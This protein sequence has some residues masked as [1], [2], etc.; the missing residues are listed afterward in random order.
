[1]P[2][3][4]QGEIVKIEIVNKDEKLLPYKELFRSIDGASEND[5]KVLA[6]LCC[7]AS[8]RVVDTDECKC[9]IEEVLGLENGEFDSAVAFWRGAK[10]LKI[11]K[12]T[13]KSETAKSEEKPQTKLENKLPDYT[14]SEMADKISQI[15]ELKGVIDECQ[16]IIGKIFS[17]SD[18]AVIVGMADRLALSGEFITMFVAY[19]VGMEKKS[20]RYVEK[21][22][23]ALYDEGID[24]VD[25][26]AKYIEN[27]EKCHEESAKIRRMMGCADRD[28]TPK[29]SNLL[30]KW[31]EEY[32]YGFEIIKKA[33][34][35]S[36]DRGI[37]GSF[38]PYMGAILDSWYNKGYKTEKDV[39]DMLAQY[40]KSKDSSVGGFDTDDFFSKAV[41]KTKRKRTTKNTEEE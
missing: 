18:V 20:L 40:K 39:D 14:Q 30:K 1:M 24:T 3:L 4:W 35:I 37:K 21:A 2:R 22:A 34:E 9:R 38:F 16:Q 12:N 10:V 36:A 32:L 5:I 26:L 13:R 33:Y 31:L 29:E 6:L 15:S 19:C 7:F 8:E 25:K 11:S 28:L 27:K 23:C 17:P 41:E